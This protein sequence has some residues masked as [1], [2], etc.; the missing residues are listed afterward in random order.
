MFLPKQATQGV[1]RQKVAQI[2]PRQARKS[3]AEGK[4]LRSALSLGSSKNL[5]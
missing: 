4:S 5:G 2:N 3:S 1:E